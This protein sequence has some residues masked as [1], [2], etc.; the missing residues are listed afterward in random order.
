V[1]VAAAQEGA[2]TTDAKDRIAMV[3]QS[4]ATSQAALK[5]YQWVETTALSLSG[6]EKVRQQNTCYYGADGGLQKVPVAADAREDKKRGLRG[7][8]VESKKAELEASL[9]DAMALLHQ[10]AP[11]DPAKVQAAKDA[12]NV[13]VSAPSASGVVRLTIKNYLMAGDQVDIDMDATKNTLQAVS[14]SS[15]VGQAK[16]KSPVAGKVSYAALAD[17]TLY[18]AKESVEVSAKSLKVD[19]Q[20]SGY[21]KKTQ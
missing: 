10:Y 8:V 3:K 11:L 5:Q 20:N 12:G 2:T 9:K 6:E 21:L 16:D 14:I 1:C 18:P 15:F 4:F 7:K 17:G 19:I 13:S